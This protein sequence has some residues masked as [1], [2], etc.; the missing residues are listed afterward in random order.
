MKKPNFSVPELITVITRLENL[1][2]MEITLPAALP[3]TIPVFS[4]LFWIK[5]GKT[6]GWFD[7]IVRSCAAKDMLPVVAWWTMP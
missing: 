7:E 6:P 2:E 4:I 5:P 3:E 1:L